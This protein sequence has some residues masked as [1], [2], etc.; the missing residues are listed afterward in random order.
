MNYQNQQPAQ[1]GDYQKNPNGGYLKRSSYSPD[2]WYGNIT[3]TPEL[4]QSIQ[5][6]GKL[7]INVN[8]VRQNQYGEARRVT[9]KPYTAPQVQQ[10]QAQQ[11]PMVQNNNGFQVPQN[12]PSAPAPQAHQDDINW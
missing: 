9:A 1:G 5:A 12:H 4:L 11:Q 7:T 8:D 10:G 3:I 2:G 6:T